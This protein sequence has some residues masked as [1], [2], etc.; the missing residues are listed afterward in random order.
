MSNGLYKIIKLRS[1][2]GCPWLQHPDYSNPNNARKP[3]ICGKM[4]KKINIEKCLNDFPKWC[5]LETYKE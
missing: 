5:P 4:E 1:C 3:I 2:L